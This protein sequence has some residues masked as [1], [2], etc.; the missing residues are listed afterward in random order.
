MSQQTAFDL[1]A[2]KLLNQVV[3]QGTTFDLVFFTILCL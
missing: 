3:P 1:V 2:T